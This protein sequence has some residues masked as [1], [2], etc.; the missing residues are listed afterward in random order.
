MPSSPSSSST[1]TNDSLRWRPEESNPTTWRGTRTVYV[2]SSSPTPRATSS[3]W[4]TCREVDVAPWDDVRGRALAMPEATEV[5]SRGNIQWRVKDKL[6]VWERPLRRSD[7]AAL[8]DTA[9]DGP[10]LGARVEHLVAKD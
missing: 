6:F 8:G 4:V 3:H 2:R 5:V 1:S 7:L 9:P 10:I